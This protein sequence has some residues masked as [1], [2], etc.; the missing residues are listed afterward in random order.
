MTRTIARTPTPAAPARSLSRLRR[1]G[2]ACLW[3]LVIGITIAAGLW[4]AARLRLVVLPVL[5]AL[6][7]ATLL[8]PPTAHLRRRGWPDGLAAL[9]TLLSSVVLIGALLAA[10]APGAVDDFNA[11]DV[12]IGGGLEEVQRW[13]AEGPLALSDRE[14]NTAID[15]AQE[16]VRANVDTVSQNL[17]LGALILVEVLTGI[18]L[19]LVLLFFFLKDG[20]RMWTWLCDLAPRS[21]RDGIRRSGNMA[22]TALSGFLRGQAIVALFDA[23]FIALALVLIGVPLVIPLAVLTF[24]GAFVPVVGATVAGLAAAL[25]ALFDDG[26]LAALMVIGAII[27]VQQLEGNILQ[28][29]VVGRSVRVHPVA[30]LLAITVGGVLGGIVGVMVAAPAVAVAGAL[31]RSLRST[32]SESSP[33]PCEPAAGDAG[34]PGPA[35]PRDV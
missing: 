1:T 20:E 27:L 19:A 28:P 7:L 17:A 30:I 34:T 24:F 22:W 6:V 14:I 31:M 13:L 35:D 3:L 12:G 23:T 33:A 26:P 15:R 10:I 16:Q 8:V 25:V 18:A 32:A 29:Y 21:Q 2:E 4:L 11:L 9:M 5:L